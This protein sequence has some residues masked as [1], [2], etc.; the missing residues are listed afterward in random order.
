[1]ELILILLAVS[2]LAI[3]LYWKSP[4]AI[5][6]RGERRVNKIISKKL[7]KQDYFLL[8]DLTLPTVRGT[9]QVDHIIV[10]RFG[11]FVIETKNMSGWIFG[12]D[13]QKHWTQVLHNHRVKFQN[14]L[15]QNFHH[16]K[17]I[18]ELL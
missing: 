7:N 11:I 9:T 14:P 15:R 3:Y 1:M 6:A 4:S 10:S 5:G 17:V 13:T 12:T 16:L 2:A 18:Q 8:Y